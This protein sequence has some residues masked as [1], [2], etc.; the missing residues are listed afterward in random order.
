MTIEMALVGCG[1]MGLRHTHGIAEA[2]RVFGKVRLA[3]VCDQHIEAADHVASEAE[4]L[5][6]YRPSTYTDFTRMLNTEKN[7]DL[8]DVVTDTRMHH[9]FAIEAL[10]AGVNVITEKPL[11]ITVEACRQTINAAR[12]S[13]KILAVAENYRR[14][15]MNRL[16]KALID[17]G[18]IGTPY[19]ML[20]TG[21][22]GGS[23][24]MHNTGWR[25]FKSR[26]GSLILERGVHLTDLTLYFMGD[27]K[28]VYAATDVFQKIRTRNTNVK[29]SL[30]NLAP[31]YKHRVEDE[32]SDQEVVEIDAEDTA[33]SVLTFE[34]GA[35]GQL[36]MSNA[37][38]GH[39]VNVN[40]IHGSGGTLLLPSSRSG[41]GPMLKLEGKDKPIVGED[42]LSLVPKWEMDDITARLWPG[43]KRITSYDMDFEEID[44]KILAVEIQDMVEAID[45]NRS[46]EVDGDM[47]MRALALAY[48]VLESGQIGQPVTMDEILSGKTSAY[49]D[50]IETA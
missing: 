40:S 10:S 7:L 4:R 30:G 36:T 28:T 35:I 27:V 46:P 25:A 43:P 34:S 14:D 1:G 48:A 33:I 8:I 6:G 13:G 2:K 45:E 18:A 23:E 29:N 9:V 26:A 11:G 16:T 12:Q 15:P 41:N 44:R 21:V 42:L 22:A 39:Q 24:L 47:G 50:G 38:H 32:F 37:S 3:A 20:H 17:N 5:M 19:Y 49:Q 31:F